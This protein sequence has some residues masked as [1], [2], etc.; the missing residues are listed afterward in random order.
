MYGKRKSLF[1]RNNYQ[2]VMTVLAV[3][4]IF[5]LMEAWGMYL[6]P[7]FKL[8]WFTSRGYIPLKH[9]IGGFDRSCRIFVEFLVDRTICRQI[10]NSKEESN[11]LCFYFHIFDLIF[12]E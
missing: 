9:P 3:L 7:K 10:F 4:S 11:A 12:I 5:G 2:I 6:P 1:I 8:S